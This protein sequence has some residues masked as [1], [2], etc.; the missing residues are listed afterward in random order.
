[1]L[2]YGRQ[3]EAKIPVTLNQSNMKILKEVPK[4]INAIVNLMLPSSL[5]WHHASQGRFLGLVP[6][7][8]MIY[9]LQYFIQGRAQGKPSFCQLD[10]TEAEIDTLTRKNKSKLTIPMLQEDPEKLERFLNPLDASR[11]EYI[12]SNI[13]SFPQVV[14]STVVYT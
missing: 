11:R 10:L 14:C 8:N 4:L 2:L 13:F 3:Q 6:M 1:M 9:Y 12:K 5:I 7:Q